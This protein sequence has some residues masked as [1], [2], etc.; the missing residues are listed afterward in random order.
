MLNM[1]YVSGVIGNVSSVHVI[2][3]T[4]VYV[5]V[6]FHQTTSEMTSF[7]LNFPRLW[8]LLVNVNQ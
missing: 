4:E 6:I 7:H 2:A 3:K 8:W 5:F 1:I